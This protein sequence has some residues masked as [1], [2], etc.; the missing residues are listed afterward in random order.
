M[1]KII[2]GATP[3]IIKGVGNDEGYIG[4]RQQMTK[5]PSH[6]ENRSIFR[7]ISQTMVWSDMDDPGIGFHGSHGILSNS[8]GSRIG[9]KSICPMPVPVR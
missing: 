1:T 5:A 3:L 7:S 8:E 9:Q 2:F 4:L 6:P